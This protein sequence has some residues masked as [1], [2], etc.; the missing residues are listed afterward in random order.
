MERFFF[1]LRIVFRSEGGLSL[2]LGEASQD[3]EA[4]IS[5]AVLWVRGTWLEMSFL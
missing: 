5:R 3:A 4:Y 2:L 1:G